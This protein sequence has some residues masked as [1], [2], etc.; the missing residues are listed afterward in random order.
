MAEGLLPKENVGIVLVVAF[1]ALS[2][3]YLLA[4]GVWK[5][6]TS[7]RLD[8]KEYAG[9]FCKPLLHKPLISNFAG[10]SSE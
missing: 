8:F 6:F 1:K 5:R 3:Q 2:I 9:D 7:A 10:P 4:G